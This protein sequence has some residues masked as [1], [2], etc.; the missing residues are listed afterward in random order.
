MKNNCL[1]ISPLPPYIEIKPLIFKGFF[2]F[3]ASKKTGF[4]PTVCPR[5]FGSNMDGKEYAS[6]L[7]SQSAW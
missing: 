7:G 3:R 6:N 5:F 4:L 1:R 2:H